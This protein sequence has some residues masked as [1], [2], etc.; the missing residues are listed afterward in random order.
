MFQSKSQV[1]Y[2]LTCLDAAGATAGVVN[3]LLTD[4]NLQRQSPTQ[5]DLPPGFSTTTTAAYMPSGASEGN[6]TGGTS[7]SL[8]PP[9]P[10]KMRRSCLRCYNAH[11]KCRAQGEGSQCQRCTKYL[12]L[13]VFVPLETAPAPPL[14]PLR[15]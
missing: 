5:C 4:R 3:V 12:F 13:C 15:Y 9:S 14:L 6:I 10:L 2:N 11:V 7:P 1:L 8:H